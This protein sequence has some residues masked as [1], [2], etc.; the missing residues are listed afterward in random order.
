LIDRARSV[1][2]DVVGVFAFGSYARS[3]ASPMSDLDLQ[4]VTHSYPTLR[5]R[6]WFAGDLHVSVGIRSIEEIQERCRVPA[7]WS[8]GFATASGG[9]WLWAEQDAVAALGD[10]PGFTHP[11]DPPE[12]EDFVESCAKA[13]YAGDS[14]GL[15]VAAQMVGETAAPL[16]RD[17]NRPIVVNTRA[18][19]VRAGAAFTT[20]PSGWA[21]D[22][23]AVLGLVPSDDVVV[24]AAVERIA[25]GVLRILRET[26]STVGDR[27]PDLTRYLFD[28]TF[29]RHL[30]V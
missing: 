26:R 23:P 10:P 28:G 21:E 12:L 4:I 22:L 2:T 17:L 3:E 24:R 25:G 18:G 20:A 6:T 30:G 1:E 15:R 19:A 16:L 7:N 13:L 29:E 11:A 5:Y 9:L 27:Q 14:I 8:L